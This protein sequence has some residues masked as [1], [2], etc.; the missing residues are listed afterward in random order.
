MDGEIVREGP[1]GDANQGAFSTGRGGQ[2]N[3]GSPGMKPVH[4]DSQDVIPEAAMRPSMEDR[5]YHIGRGGQ[6][7]AHLANEGKD[8]TQHEGLAD[9][10]KNKIFKTKKPDGTDASP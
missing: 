9:K 1:I 7:N 6:G 10:L 2:G 5:D 4:R 8:K 3:I